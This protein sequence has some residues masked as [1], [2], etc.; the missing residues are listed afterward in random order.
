MRGLRTV[1]VARN[2]TQLRYTI[3]IRTM[4]SLE[5]ECD[6]GDRDFV[7]AELWE[8]GSMG[9]VELSASAVRA[10]FEDESQDIRALSAESE[11]D[12][13][14]TGAL[15]D[16]KGDDAIDADDAKNERKSREGGE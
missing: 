1:V 8:R 11:A 13:D 16:E 10:F 5:I 9:I 14:L 6:P 7:I 2:A 15:S 3:N 4:F 12:A